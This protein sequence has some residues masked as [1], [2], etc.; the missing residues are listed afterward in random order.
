MK[1]GVLVFP[2]SNCDHDTYHVISKVIG[3]PV[4]FIWHRNTTLNGC[5]VVFLPGGF[6][7]GDYLRCGAIASFSPIMQAVKEFAA[8][9]GYVVGICNGFQILCESKLLPGTL[10]RNRDLKFKCQFTHLRVEN[11]GTPFTRNCLPSSVLSLPIAHG[12]GNYFCT[13]EEL[14]DMQAHQQV[15]FRYA[16]PEGHIT[17]EA[18]PNGSLD[19][20]AGIIN[21]AGN[22]L[23]MM[24]HPERACE[25]SLGG[26][27]GLRLFDS[28]L[29]SVIERLKARDA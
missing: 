17:D 2:G 21:R 7:Y 25:E 11:N 1:F 8:Q 20:I 5:D 22:V 18:N 12:E 27:Q 10:L 14:S 3:Q 13:A 6:S 28:L 15:V 16:T 24:P 23:G 19:N 29:T 26:S 9:G 4:Q